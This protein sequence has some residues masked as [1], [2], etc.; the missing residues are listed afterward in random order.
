TGTRTGGRRWVKILGFLAIGFV[1][2]LVLAAA[3]G[4]FWWGHFRTTP[5]Y[6]L[7]LIVDAAQRND[8]ATFDRLVD[9]DKIVANLGSQV[10]EKLASPIGLIPGLAV[11]RALQS[12]PP[13]L[14]QPLKQGVRDHIAQEMKKI[15]GESA[16]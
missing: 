15:S 13:A 3:G 6:S 9:S 1:A 8:M 7:A 16:P 14:V 2:I 5:T 4:F 11:N 10:R 12:V